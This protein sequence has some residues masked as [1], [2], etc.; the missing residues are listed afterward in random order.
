M[1]DR[2]VKVMY[3]TPIGEPDEMEV[4]LTTEESRFTDAEEWAKVNGFDR[5]RIAEIDM[6]RP[7]DFAGTVNI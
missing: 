6:S 1:E 7:P 5:I 4:V 3:A 2:T